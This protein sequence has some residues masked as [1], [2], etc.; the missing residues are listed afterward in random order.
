[1]EI[2]IEKPDREALRAL[3]VD[4]WETWECEPSVFDWSYDAPETCYILE[5]RARVRTP[6]GEVTFGP[7]DL[8]RFPEG[9]ACTWTVV[10]RVR[11]KY[12]FG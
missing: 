11:K 12:S 9:L 2:R 8:V 7:G 10:E 4:G 5:G 6:S 3:G 1:M